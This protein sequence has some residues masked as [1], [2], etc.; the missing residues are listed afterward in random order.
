MINN[1]LKP[2][3]KLPWSHLQVST[4]GKVYSC[5]ETNYKSPLGDLNKESLESIWK[6][7]AFDKFRSKMMDGSPLPECARCDKLEKLGMD[8]LRLKSQREW[9]VPDQVPEQPVYLDLRLDNTCNLKCRTCTPV[10]S[11]SLAAELDPEK[12]EKIPFNER[13]EETWNSIKDWL[14]GIKR[15]YIAG[16]EPLLSEYHYKII[17]ELV[18]IKNHSVQL[19]YNTN[20]THLPDKILELWSYLPNVHV[21]A[22]IDGINEIGEFIRKGS[23]WNEI[24][25]NRA[26]LTKKCPHVVFWVDWT[27]S[28]YNVFHLPEALKYLLETGFIKSFDEFRL[29][30]L[31]EPT[32]FNPSILNDAEKIQLRELYNKTLPEFGEN[33]SKA[34]ALFDTIMA[35]INYSDKR[36]H[37]IDFQVINSKLNA[38]RGERSDLL[39][40]DLKDLMGKKR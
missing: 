30:I 7:D 31:D 27:L 20:F 8:S 14:P 16:G 11:S 10:Y 38:A 37:R 23:K 33:E 13:K 5:C 40:P 17:R 36:S 4:N 1:N 18:E 34:S 28:I 15:I 32:H 3:C 19:I 2:Y 26:K 29:N 21:S 39:F 9:S 24:E 22:S 6:G 12:R 35:S 25:A